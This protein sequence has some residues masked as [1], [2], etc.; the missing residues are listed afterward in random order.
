MNR[1][2][3]AFLFYFSP[4]Y[5]LFIYV[6]FLLLLLYRFL[7]ILPIEAEL[8]ICTWQIHGIYSYVCNIML[9]WPTLWS[10]MACHGRPAA[11]FGSIVLRRQR[12]RPQNWVLVTSWLQFSFIITI[13][14]TRKMDESPLCW[15]RQNLYQ[16]RTTEQSREQL[17]CL[18]K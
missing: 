18:P 13:P 7:L 5:L 3:K 11:V 6:I 10:A 8:C 17:L 4:L 1:Q 15:A 12:H 9:K 16:N 2:L 14:C